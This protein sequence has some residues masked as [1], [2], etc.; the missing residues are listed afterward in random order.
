[1]Y[2]ASA[3][4]ELPTRAFDP[5]HSIAAESNIRKT[6]RKRERSKEVF[7]FFFFVKQA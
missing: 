7:F 5:D 2:P 6:N 3:T 4:Q 1:M